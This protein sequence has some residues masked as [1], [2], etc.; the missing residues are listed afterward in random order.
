MEKGELLKIRTLLINYDKEIRVIREECAAAKAQADSK[1]RAA[2]LKEMGV[3]E[4]LAKEMG[5][6]ITE[7]QQLQIQWKN[8]IDKVHST[9]ERS[10]KDR[11]IQLANR[12]SRD[13]QSL[14]DAANQST[15]T[16]NG[17]LSYYK[18]DATKYAWRHLFDCE[19]KALATF[20]SIMVILGIIWGLVITVK[21]I[22]DINN[23]G[24]SEIFSSTLVYL[25]LYVSILY[26]VIELVWSFVV[27]K[28]SIEDANEQ[29]RT[30]AKRENDQILYNIAE[31]KTKL[32]KFDATFGRYFKTADGKW[33]FA[34]EKMPIDRETAE[35][36]LQEAK[37]DHTCPKLPA[38]INK[39]K[40]EIN[41]QSL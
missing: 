39:Y 6:T 32:E 12:I 29:R 31:A 36:L 5:A 30:N 1:C 22:I 19:S 8:Y 14:T 2:I 38:G 34:P 16:K 25:G 26:I 35:N 17:H 15:L 41:Y 21:S 3:D 24:I 7:L 28:Q 33:N 23:L 20:R 13:Y 27:N 40:F 37:S 4:K 18:E 11:K 9:F 10:I